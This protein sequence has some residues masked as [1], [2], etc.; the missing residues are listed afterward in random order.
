MEWVI[1]ATLRPLY[2]RERPNT[3]CTGGWVGAGAV[4]GGCR[5]SRP[6][7]GF[8]PRTVHPVA[9]RFTDYAILVRFLQ[10]YFNKVYICVAQ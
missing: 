4:L 2:P 9:I 10:H 5:N 6:S 8:D 3:H 1:N 7:P